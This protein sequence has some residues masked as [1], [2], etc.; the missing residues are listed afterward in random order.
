MYSNCGF[1]FDARHLSTN[2]STQRETKRAK[3]T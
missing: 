1:E 3:R 2:T